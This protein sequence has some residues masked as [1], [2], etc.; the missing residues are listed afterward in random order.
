MAMEMG[1]TG[2]AAATAGPDRGTTASA[3]VDFQW[4][5]PNATKWIAKIQ[6]HSRIRA[7]GEVRDYLHS[8]NAGILEDFSQSVFGPLLQL[9]MDS[10]LNR[11]VLHQVITRQITFDRMDLYEAWF[12]MGSQR[13]R[14]SKSE[15]CLTT[16][17][18]FGSST[19]DPN[20]ELHHPPNGV[21][22]RVLNGQVIRAHDLYH[23]FVARDYNNDP[24]VAL[25]MEMVIVAEVVL[26][27]VDDKHIVRP[28][29]WALVDDRQ[30][31]DTF[32]W[33]KF[34]FSATLHYL[35]AIVSP[36][37]PPFEDPEWKKKFEYHF[38]GFLLAF[39]LWVYEALLELR[40]T[41]ATRL[42]YENLL[43]RFRH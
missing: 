32:P 22:M 7:I 12:Q 23:R 37:P 28:W 11:V 41:F 18:K 17:L 6:T 3:T 26:F 35:N 25:K 10:M 1:S 38:Y 24:I 9:D 43:P 40:R 39:Q 15:F 27:R 8:I 36:P 21:W 33:G 16:G 2:I 31:W 20:A 34:V 5:R 14:W 13:L 42:N 4:K 29:L 30:R 19:F